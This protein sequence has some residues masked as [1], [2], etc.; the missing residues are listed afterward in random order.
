MA[1]NMARNA[2]LAS[3]PWPMLGANIGCAD[4]PFD[5]PTVGPLCPHGP[6][7][8]QPPLRRG[9]GATR[10]LLPLSAPERPWGSAPVVG[11]GPGGE[12]TRVYAVRRSRAAPSSASPPTANTSPS[13]SRLGAGPP[14][15]ASPDCGRTDGLAWPAGAAGGAACWAAIR[16]LTALLESWARVWMSFRAVC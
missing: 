14:M 6:T 1:K 11:W 8:P 15:G 3:L 5:P 10:C 4:I 7:A 13:A 12:V 16:S 9:E 2:N